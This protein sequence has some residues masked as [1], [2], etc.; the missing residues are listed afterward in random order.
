MD[1]GGTPITL[2]ETKLEKDLGVNIDPSLK[3][4]QHI[5]IQVNKANRLLGM[6]RRSFEFLDSETVKKLFTS[7]IHPHLEY[8]DVSCSPILQRDKDLL[9]GVQ[10]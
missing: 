5:E 4:S 1:N 8:L 10:N 9:E 6:I 2:E 7:L 3:F